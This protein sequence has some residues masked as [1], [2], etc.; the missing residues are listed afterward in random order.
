MNK[1]NLVNTT[2]IHFLFSLLMLPPITRGGQSSEKLFER[3][4]DLKTQ[5][6][7]WLESQQL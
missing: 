1:L 2:F 3:P 7:C 5:A 4:R 6:D